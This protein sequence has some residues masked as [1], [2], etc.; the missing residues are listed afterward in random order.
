MESL[1]QRRGKLDGLFGRGGED[2]V[3]G[4]EEMNSPKLSS[5]TMSDR[6]KCMT[7]IMADKFLGRI[8]ELH[9]TGMTWGGAIVQAH[10]ELDEIKMRN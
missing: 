3:C 10:I 7:R 4:D 8:E 2:G 5:F 1:P 9:N 6:N